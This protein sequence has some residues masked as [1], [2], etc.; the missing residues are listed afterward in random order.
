LIISAVKMTKMQKTVFRHGNTPRVSKFSKLE[1]TYMQHRFKDGW[2]T[3]VAEHSIRSFILL[4]L[5]VNN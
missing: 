3:E 2:A 5:E 4:S 1:N